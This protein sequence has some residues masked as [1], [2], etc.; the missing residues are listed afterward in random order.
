M[1]RLS[2]VQPSDDQPR[3]KFN[4]EPLEELADSIRQ[5][6][7]IQPIVV[8]KKKSGY[9]IIAGERRW[10][11]ARMAGL[12]EVPVIVRELDDQKMM[13]ISLIENLQREDLDPVEEARAYRRLMDEYELTQEEIAQRVSK[14]RATVANSL[15]L[16]KLGDVILK[17][18]SDGQLSAG[19]ARALLALEDE[20]LR[21]ELA[22]R[23]I[24][25]KLSVRETES[26]VRRFQSVSGS[27]KRVRTAVQPIS[28]AARLVYQEMEDKM[29]QSLGTRVA[30]SPKTDQK[31]KIE[32]EYYS[33]DE[34]E[35]LYHLLRSV[36]E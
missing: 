4:D 33:M 14:N 5:Y 36:S 9:E 30:L 10:R 1:V 20:D 27:R 19:H 23:I 6:G 2:K 15:R 32:I 17:Y 24:K 22:E 21:N 26:L 16:L 3:K 13:E 31:G 29:K 8:R 28:E 12:T 34:L 25:E 35:R 11:A 18:L 7:L